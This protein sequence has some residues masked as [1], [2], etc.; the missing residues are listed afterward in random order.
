MNLTT[1]TA[2]VPT[3]TFTPSLLSINRLGH[4]LDLYNKECSKEVVFNMRTADESESIYEG[5]GR[6]SIF[7]EKGVFID[8]YF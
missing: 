8:T 1:T 2:L 3:Q 7:P 4:G 6:H 5:D